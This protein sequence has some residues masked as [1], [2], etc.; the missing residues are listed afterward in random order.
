MIASNMPTSAQTNVTNILHLEDSTLLPVMLII[1]ALAL[2]PIL[3]HTAEHG[4]TTAHLTH[5]FHN[6]L[7]TGDGVHQRF[8]RGTAIGAGEEEVGVRGD[9]ERDFGQV[10]VF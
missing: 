7:A 8:Q 10:E 2:R 6:P 4:F 1:W 5:H 9:A 3:I